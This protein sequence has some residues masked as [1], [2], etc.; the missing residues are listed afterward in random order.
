MSR[1]QSS[2]A[3]LLALLLV[4]AGLTVPTSAQGT[5]VAV[6]SMQSKR[7][8]H[9]MTRLPT[10]EVVAIGGTDPFLTYE[11]L[12]TAEVYDPATNTWGLTGNLNAGREEHA[13]TLLADGRILVT[14]GQNPVSVAWYP[15][16][17]VLNSAEIYNPASHTFVPAGPMNQ[18]RLGHQATRLADGRVLLTGG[19]ANQ[20]IIF[21]SY[22][23]NPPETTATAEIFNPATNTFTAVAGSMTM[24]RAYHSATLLADGRVLIV[25]GNGTAAN[26]AEIFDPASATFSAIAGPTAPRRVHGAIRLDDGRV[27]IAGGTSSSGTAEFFDPATQAFTALP[28][29]ASGYGFWGVIE[30]MTDG[31]I[32]MYNDGAAQLFT[33][34]ANTFTAVGGAGVGG[35]F[36]AGA[37]LANNRVLVSGGQD[38]VPY[39]FVSREAASI[40]VPNGAPLAK[41]GPDQ[42]VPAGAGCTALVTLDG[43]LSS[44]PDGDALTL[45]WTQGANTVGNGASVQLSLG[46]GTHVFTLT[47]SDGHGGTATDE[48]TVVVADTLPPM[49]AAPLPMSATLEQAGPAGTY[50]AIATPSATDHCDAAPVVTVTGLPAGSIFPAGDTAVTFSAT[51]ATGNA[52]SFS[53]TVTVR[54]S[55]AP[56][57]TVPAPITAE[58]TNAAGAAVSFTASATDAV[59]GSPAVNCTPASGSTFAIGTTTVSCSSTDAAGNRGAASFVVAVGDTIAP[60]LSVPAPITVPATGP[61]GATVTY[62]V[63][64]TDAVTASPAIICSP[65]SGNTFPIGTT[66]VACSA[67]DAA[68]NRGTASFNV[69]VA[70]TT[71]PEVTSVTTNPGQLWPPNHKMVAVKVTAA[72]SDNGSPAACRVTGVTSN[73]PSDNDW[74]ITG[75]MSLELRAERLGTAARTYTIAIQCTDAAGNASIGSTNVIVPHDQ[76]K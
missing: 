49:F 64:A 67:T 20:G 53:I 71:G 34:A 43:S 11:S 42:Q 16:T 3:L 13:A 37:A 23:A 27:L 39:T 38:F 62:S 41:A 36:A 76:R 17:F 8:L 56:V 45:A 44:D 10:G 21:G 32:Y 4:V 40:F 7:A 63:A 22:G 6:A 72:A 52:D 46:P 28:A 58:A 50:F 48:V 69:T 5:H 61:S 30:R 19:H 75:A 54:D 9:T 18:Y 65:A 12:V 26:T 68:G 31:R 55:I 57:V 51:D 2:Q 33:P 47:V 25:G 66:A 59:T 14:G 70:D 1:L 24:A 29:L 35:L 15:S 74:N 73:Q 60:V